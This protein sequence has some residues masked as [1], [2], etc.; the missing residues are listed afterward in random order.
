MP[1]C[2]SC[3]LSL[4]RCGSKI[5]PN[6]AHYSRSGILTGSRQPIWPC[7]MRAADLGARRVAVWGLGREGRAAIK[8]LRRHHPDLP[9]LL[10]DDAADAVVPDIAGANVTV[11]F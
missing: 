2:A 9:L 1:W 6:T 11:A 7:S 10:L 3:R 4:L 5:M 8:F